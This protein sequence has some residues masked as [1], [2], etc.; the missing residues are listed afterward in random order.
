MYEKWQVVFHPHAQRHG[1]TIEDVEYAYEHYAR[2]NSSKIG[3]VRR[4]KFTGPCFRLALVRSIEVI[5][6]I[7]Y[8]Y[9][10]MTI[11][12]VNTETDTFWMEG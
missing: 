7:D 2:V 9:K 12:H 10:R 6:D 11:F 5:A 4:L 8:R 1:F 3:E